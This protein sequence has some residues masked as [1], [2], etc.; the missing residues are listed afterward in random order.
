M[1]SNWSYYYR[2]KGFFVIILLHVVAMLLLALGDAFGATKETSKLYNFLNE[3]VWY[4]FGLLEPI[5]YF[6]LW[7]IEEKSDGKSSQPTRT[8]NEKTNPN[9]ES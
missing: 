4:L 1:N 7:M 5:I 2:G 3:K 8:T 9:Q 6:F